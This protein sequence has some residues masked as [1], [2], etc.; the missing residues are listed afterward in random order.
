MKKKAKA[1]IAVAIILVISILLSSYILFVNYRV[2]AFASEKIINSNIAGEYIKI[3]GAGIHYIEK[4]KGDKNILLVHGF[5]GGTYS[6]RHNIEELAKNYKVY[7]ID[8]KGFG[9]SQRPYDSDYSHQ[10]QAKI[11]LEFLEKKDIDKVTAFGHSMGGS[12]LLLAYDIDPARFEK[13]VLIDSAGLNESSFKF[14]KFMNQPI[15]NIIYYNYVVN[16]DKFVN[17]LKSA[18]FDKSFV[19]KNLIDLYYSPLKI[20]NTNIVLK[21]IIKDVQPYTVENILKNINVPVLIVW[22][23]KDTWIDKKYAY[24][25]RKKI[26]GSKLEIILNAGHLP[27][28][29]KYSAFNKIISD[30]L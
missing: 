16:K 6:Y 12:I 2:D 8:L 26:E 1:I 21:E 30:F 14:S 27:M 24:E 4:G 23:D 7:A 9:Y 3:R 11:I 13:L 22:G 25:F 5:G 10:E 28:E 15:V 17:F 18:Y 19:D 20:R 29:E